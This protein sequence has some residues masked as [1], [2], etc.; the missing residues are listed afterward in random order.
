MLPPDGWRQEARPYSRRQNQGL[1][2][3]EITALKK[4]IEGGHSLRE[5]LDEFP[6]V[7]REMAVQALEE[8]KESLLGTIA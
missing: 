1:P 5:F 3:L 7:T 8:A 6:T 4:R 2:R